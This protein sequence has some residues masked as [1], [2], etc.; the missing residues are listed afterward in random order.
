MKLIDAAIIF[1]GAYIVVLLIVLAIEQIWSS[2][3][4]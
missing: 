4:L 1:V 3:C 2:R